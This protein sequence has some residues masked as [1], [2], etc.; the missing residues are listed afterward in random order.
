MLLCY[1]LQT[2][3]FE[4]PLFLPFNL[5]GQFSEVLNYN[6]KFLIFLFLTFPFFGALF[7]KA[8]S[9]VITYRRMLALWA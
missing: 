1:M 7:K 4:W 9:K 2:V 5:Y 3:P 6:F 8:F